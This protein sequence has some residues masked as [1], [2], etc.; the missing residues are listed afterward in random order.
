M[1][2]LTLDLGSPFAPWI[3]NN[4][5]ASD[6]SYVCAIKSMS[7]VASQRVAPGV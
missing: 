4:G 3:P 1:K 7:Y 2:S 5:A 6:M